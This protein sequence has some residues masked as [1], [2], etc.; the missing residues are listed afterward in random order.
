MELYVK[1]LTQGV[2]YSCC[3]ANVAGAV[4]P[5]ADSEKI[6]QIDQE[7]SHRHVLDSKSLRVFDAYI[8]PGQVSFY[9]RHAADS[10]L[11]C[12]EGAD[13]TSEESGKQ[14]VP[15]PPI[16]TGLI[17]YKPYATQPLVHRVRNIGKDAF[18]I[19]DIEVLTPAPGAVALPSLPDMFKTVL[20]NERVRVSKLVLHTNQTTG[21]VAYSGP[22]LFAVDVP[23]KL[24]FST[25]S[26]GRGVT[27]N[28]P[29]GYL[30][31]GENSGAEVITNVG[32]ATIELVS[33]EVK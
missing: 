10:V 13:V 33:I 27:V 2:L 6:V 29:R 16:P 1:L 28:A 25:A 31:V 22:H 21:P 30:D 12:L 4:E 11:V 26:Q 32:D 18:R 19:L 24:T 5:V 8:Q 15:R 23:G 9:H 17:Y 20:E 7:P 14:L 3:L